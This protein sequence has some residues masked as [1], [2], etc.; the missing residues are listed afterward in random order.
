MRNIA[1]SR[2]TTSLTDRT[3]RGPKEA[4]TRQ[5]FSTSS[6]TGESLPSPQEIVA[7]AR[8]NSGLNA[9]DA[10]TLAVEETKRFRAGQ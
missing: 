2:P 3:P 10:Q 4:M 6:S 8:T 1:M 7:K 5:G 9:T